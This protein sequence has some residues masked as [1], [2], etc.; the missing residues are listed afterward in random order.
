MKEMLKKVLSVVLVACLAFGICSNGLIAMAADL[1]SVDKNGD[2]K[3]DAGEYTGFYRTNSIDKHNANADIDPKIVIDENGKFV[4]GEGWAHFQYLATYTYA[5]GT[6]VAHGENGDV[7]IDYAEDGSIVY[8]M[9]IPRA[10]YAGE[11]F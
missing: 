9:Y 4:T 11:W 2:G 8:G 3:L 7:A 10:T 5:D 6:V 1:K